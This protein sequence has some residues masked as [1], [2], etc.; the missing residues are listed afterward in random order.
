LSFLRD[1]ILP[2]IASKLA[3]W[4]AT[5]ELV[6]YLEKRAVFDR[7][8]ARADELGLPLVNYGCGI[9]FRHAIENS[10]YNLDVVTRPNV[11][12]FML[13]EPDS[14]GLPFDDDSTIVFCSH[15]LEHTENPD[16][17]LRELNR[18]AREVYVLTP[19]PV[20]LQ[21]WLHLGHKWVF[22]KRGRI[23]NP[24]YYKPNWLKLL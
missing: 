24:F 1:M 23:K 16:V 4:W 3:L 12:R 13:V 7:A 10:D 5:G 6:H 15:V 8:R 18:I 2:I 14:S 20:L 11:P 17:L 21:T 22:I 9:W 19:N